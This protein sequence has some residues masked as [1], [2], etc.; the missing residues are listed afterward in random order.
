MRKKI[1]LFILCIGFGMACYADADASTVVS[2]KEI[3][4]NMIGLVC[5]LCM[6]FIIQWRRKSLR[7]DGS[8][9]WSLWIFIVD[10]KINIATYVIALIMY[11]VSKVHLT[12]MECFGLGVIPNKLIDW[13]QAESGY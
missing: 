11:F 2:D 8:A 4:M 10:N 6:Y 1:L 12:P 9:K 13:I 5:G 3:T 7:D